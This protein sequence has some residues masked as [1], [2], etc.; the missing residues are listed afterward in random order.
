MFFPQV[1]LFYVKASGMEQQIGFYKFK[2][3]DTTKEVGVSMGNILEKRLMFAFLQM[4]GIIKLDEYFTKPF[5]PTS[6]FD[7]PSSPGSS[8][9]WSPFITRRFHF[10]RELD[11]ATNNPGSSFIGDYLASDFF[12]SVHHYFLRLNS[13]PTPI[14]FSSHH[15]DQRLRISQRLNYNDHVYTSESSKSTERGGHFI[16][17]YAN[18]I[19]S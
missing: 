14:F 12:K 3:N 17:V 6:F 7:N 2:V 18:H 15:F 1:S 19:S 13:S 8:E 16:K 5:K 10:G 4:N 11:R 9:L